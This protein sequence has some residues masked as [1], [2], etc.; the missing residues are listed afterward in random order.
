MNV[1]RD[2]SF[3][4]EHLQGLS[5]AEAQAR[6]QQDGYNEL[7]SSN[8]RGTFAIALTVV[9]EPMFSLLMVASIIYLISA[10]PGSAHSGRF[11]LSHHGDHDF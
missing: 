2:I 1:V 3:E 4:S 5:S 7:P 11:D 9:R 6:L 10:T 8:R